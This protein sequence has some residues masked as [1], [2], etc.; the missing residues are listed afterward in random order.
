MQLEEFQ[1][2]E[3]TKALYKQLPAVM[4]GTFG[5]YALT[6][7]ALWSSQDHRLLLSWHAAALLVLVLRWRSVRDYF[8]TRPAPQKMR[9]WLDRVVFWA[10]WTGLVWGVVPLLFVRQEDP[11]T[12]LILAFVFPG[13][14]AASAS[15]LALSNRVFLAFSVPMAGLFLLACVLQGGTLLYLV[16]LMI[17]VFMCIMVIFARN[18]E[19]MFR[20]R[21][22]FQYENQSLVQQLTQQKETAENAVRAKNQFLAAASHDLRQPLHASGMFI[23][24]LSHLKLGDEAQ[25]I[26]DKL[27]LSTGSL[28]S[29]LHELLDISRLDAKVVEYLPKSFDLNDFLQRIFDEYAQGH[30]H[31]EIELRLSMVPNMFAFSDPML[32]ERVV[33]NVIENALKFTERGEI[34]IAAA[35]VDDGISLSISDTGIGIPESE[36]DHV[37]QEFTQLNNSERDRQRGL[38]LGLTIVRQLCALMDIDLRLESAV[39]K[40]TTITL[41]LQRTAEVIDAEREETGT[42]MLSGRVVLVIDDERDIRDGMVRVLGQAGARVVAAQSV[43]AAIDALHQAELVPECI[44][45]DFRL[46]DDLNGVQA[47]AQIRDEFNLTIPA[48]LVTGDTSPESL[49][50]AQAGGLSVQHKP[51]SPADLRLSIWRELNQLR[52]DEV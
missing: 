14:L 36:H 15:S 28:N 26:L 16:G 52:A 47:V 7:T 27:S 25:Q 48:V 12:A 41:V 11:M 4:A 38:G 49:L 20:E 6:T 2:F 37:F 13:Y 46:R 22:A 32:L 51:V 50:F 39:N 8:R 18:A 44:V 1:L 23:D 35:A 19:A 45:A 30:A 5:V 40:G 21:A 33:R 24:A 42:P 34:C 31:P 3:Q 29:L 17:F 9:P 43:S 10:A